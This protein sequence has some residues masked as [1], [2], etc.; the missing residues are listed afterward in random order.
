MNMHS[1]ANEMLLD[2]PREDNDH[3][4]YNPMDRG[5]YGSTV[6]GRESSGTHLLHL[7]GPEFSGRGMSIETVHEVFH[8]CC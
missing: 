2:I 5:G 8:L 6:R 1:T 7:Q 4:M 3:D